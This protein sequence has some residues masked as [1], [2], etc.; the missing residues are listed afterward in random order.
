MKEEYPGQYDYHEEIINAFP[1]YEF[2]ECGEDKHP[3]N[4]FMGED[5][6]FGGYVYVEPGM[7]QN[8]ALLD[9]ASMHPHSILA[10]NC[11][12]E[13]TDRFRDLVDARIA[14]KRK[15][16]DKAKTML[17]G[18]LSPYL[19]DE[20]TA[21]ALSTAL[22][23][24]I[25][26]VYGLTSAKFQNPF[27]DPRNAN[28]IVALRG[29]LFMVTLKNEIIK[30]GY[31][32]FHFK[33]DSVKIA[34]AD[35]EIIDFCMEFA[36]QYGYEFEHEATY[37]KICIVNGSTYIAKYDEYGQRN[38]GGK[39]ANEWTA[40]AAQFQQPYVFKTLFS[41]KEI[42]FKDM[43]ETKEVKGALYLDFNEELPDVTDLEKELNKHAKELKDGNITEEEFKKEYD[44]LADDI[45]KGH[46]YHF[47]GK[48]GEFCP[49]ISGAGGGELLRFDNEKYSSATG[50]KGYRWMEAEMVQQT[51]KV[52]CIDK[53]YYTKLVDEAVADI[54]QYGDFE[55]FVAN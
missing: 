39:H 20:E 49:I 31:K 32:P 38:K 10:M 11:F 37:K 51:G 52:D 15:D 25:N 33:T 43:C 4:M 54:S 19:G 40:T 23:I 9:I 3:H 14:I 41:H 26:S 30:K 28:N 44:K 27:R 34:D 12:G 6:G 35:Q 16:W 22:K 55:W 13:Y 7:Y 18:A 46:S 48:V 47:V 24:P 53:S 50:A 36:K 45:A 2:I 42:E 29:A 1:G 5:V 8:A 21:D 17:D